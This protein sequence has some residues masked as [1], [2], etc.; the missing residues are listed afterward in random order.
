[1]QIKRTDEKRNAPTGWVQAARFYKEMIVNQL[2]H[3]EIGSASAAMLQRIK[4][5]RA[6]LGRHVALVVL[7]IPAPGWLENMVTTAA[8]AWLNEAGL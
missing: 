8:D 1:M 7:R 2:Y 4:A 3:D 5:V 6:R